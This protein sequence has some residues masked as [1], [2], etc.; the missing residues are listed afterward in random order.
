[1]ASR[2]SPALAERPDVFRYDDF[3]RFLKDFFAFE[4]ERNPRFSFG[5]FARRAGVSRS[6]FKVVTDYSWTLTEDFACRYAEALRMAD[7]ERRFFLLLVR[8]NQAKSPEEREKA[9]R[10]LKAAHWMMKRR[11]LN[12]EETRQIVSRWYTGLVL[13]LTKLAD[14]RADPAWI[15]RRTGGLIA[16]GQAAEA[17]AIL[18]RHRLIV[19][20]KG[21]IDPTADVRVQAS[22][23][24]S[25]P[26]PRDEAAVWAWREGSRQVDRAGGSGTSR[27][28]LLT[29]PRGEEEELLQEITR[30][31]L[32]AVQRRQRADG[33]LCTT[34][35]GVFPLTK[36]TGRSS[37][38]R[39][40]SRDGGRIVS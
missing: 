6:H 30:F 33:E 22:Y 36:P 5:V 38:R 9:E 25:G 11:V 18:K 27:E 7:E 39:T 15:H 26:P 16:K 35:L 34:L 37:R 32:G 8:F 29:L 12:V 3:R 20:R 28:F 2:S 17:L 23:F 40:G 13:G 19:L 24:G 21:R 31:A 1:M 14:F 10:E 4:K